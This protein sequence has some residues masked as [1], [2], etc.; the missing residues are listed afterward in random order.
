MLK[1]LENELSSELSYH[2]KHHT[3]DVLKVTKE[4]CAHENISNY[5]TKLIKTACLFHDAGF[6][7][8]RI[9]HEKYGCKIAEDY[10][11]RYGYNPDQIKRICGM[12]MATKI[13]Q[14]P[15][16]N[17]EKIIC[18]ADLDYLGRD[19]FFTIGNSLFKE[20]KTQGVVEDEF[21]WNEM[22]INF[23]ENHSF[24]TSTNIN[25]RSAKK[26][27]HLEEL[28]LNNGSRIDEKTNNQNK[29]LK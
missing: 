23:L 3:E 28:K 15:K 7:N 16:N 5:E 22:Q 14:S 18:D 4:L 9:E 29:D 19:D 27:A 8:S 17:L 10:L 20:L 25:R 2:G 21:S 13:P 1:K 12:I 26:Q 11:P 6:I 24:F